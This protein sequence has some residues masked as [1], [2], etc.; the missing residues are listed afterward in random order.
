MKPKRR[1]ASVKAPRVKVPL[2]VWASVRGHCTVYLG[3]WCVIQC[4]TRE[5][6]L[7]EAN[8]I[9]RELSR[10]V[11]ARERRKART[12]S[13]FERDMASILDSAPTRKLVASEAK[14][15]AKK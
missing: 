12:S 1:P 13:A 8:G 15:R 7:A 4:V 11:A 10:L 14:R 9:N 5:S 3:R 6:A 2:V